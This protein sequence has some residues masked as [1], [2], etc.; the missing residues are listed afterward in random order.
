MTKP[1]L[2]K[3]HPDSRVAVPTP[4]VRL[5]R[6]GESLLMT[7]RI[8]GDTSMIELPEPIEPLVKQSAARRADHL[9]E[10]TCFE[11]FVRPEGATGYLEF[12]FSPSLQ[13]AAYR[14]A[15]YRDGMQDANVPVPVLVSTDS[16]HRF[17]LSAG[18]RLPDWG[19]RAWFLNC[20]AIMREKDGNTSHW[21]LK[22]R[23]GAPDFHHPDCF[24]LRLPPTGQT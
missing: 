7:F 24:V 8:P 16:L 13:W 14:F 4:W 22:H 10:K 6:E 21:A 18:V 11:C 5:G 19:D 1:I 23:A 9:W 2:L 20:A 17:E 12:N 15:G 3:P